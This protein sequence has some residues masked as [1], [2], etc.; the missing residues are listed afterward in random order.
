MDKP[1]D[2][3]HET[4]PSEQYI[5]PESRYEDPN[6]S[7]IQRVEGGG[8]IKKVSLQELPKAIKIFYYLIISVV[9]VAVISLIVSGYLK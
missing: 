3:I 2:P 6:T 4:E 7:A 5:Q 8:P 1:K 9:A